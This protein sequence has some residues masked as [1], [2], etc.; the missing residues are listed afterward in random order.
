MTKRSF[1]LTV[2]AGLL[3]SVVLAT[4]SQAASVTVTTDVV[5]SLPSTA[6]GTFTDIDV[7][8]S[9]AVDPIS[10]LKVVSSN[11][12]TVTL[13]EGPGNT[14]TATFGAVTSGEILWSFV[15]STSPPINATG[16]SFSGSATGIADTVLIKKH[17]D[18]KSFYFVADA[19]TGKTV[20]KANVEFFGWKY[21]WTNPA[22]G[23]FRIDTSSF[24][25]TSDAASGW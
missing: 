22:A 5:F 7:T 23:Q 20:G 10:S 19:V 15:T 2:A 17:L 18:G 3:A 24:A 1:F 13:A 11:V 25:R 16:F 8:Y 9:P 14:I 21:V 12:G 6:T 4:P